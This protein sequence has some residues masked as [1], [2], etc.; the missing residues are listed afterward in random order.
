M[1]SKISVFR[2]GLALPT[3]YPAP[4]KL[5]VFRGPPPTPGPYDPGDLERVAEEME[6][7]RLTELHTQYADILR[8]GVETTESAIE[9]ANT[10]LAIDHRGVELKQE[11]KVTNI[12]I[13][14]KRFIPG[15]TP[16]TPAQLKKLYEALTLSASKIPATGRAKL[17]HAML[18]SKAKVIKHVIEG[19]APSRKGGRKPDT[20]EQKA[21]KEAERLRLKALIDNAKLSEKEAKIEA[22]HLADVAEREKIAKT[23]AEHKQ[24]KA[25]ALAEEKRLKAS[26]LAEATLAKIETKEVNVAKSK[27]GQTKPKKFV[28]KKPE[29]MAGGGGSS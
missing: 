24:A 29:D 19:T 10:Q 14:G 9:V 18:I 1:S 27:E 3:D 22:K 8:E 2:G 7:D 5:T 6:V 11:G 20:P 12:Y 15:S 28:I 23:K 21:K 25:E 26:E 17:T 16:A 13:D 4:K